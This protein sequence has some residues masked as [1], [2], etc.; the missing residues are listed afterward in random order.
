MI[1][2]DSEILSKCDSAKGKGFQ[3]RI[4]PALCRRRERMKG[5]E[6]TNLLLQLI[7]YAVSE[8]TL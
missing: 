3:P 1:K 4:K 7:T 8:E 5:R 2:F 6:R